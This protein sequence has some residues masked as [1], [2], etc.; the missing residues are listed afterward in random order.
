MTAPLPWIE[1]NHLA[2]MT[3]RVEESITFYKT[4]LGFRQVERPNFDFRGAWLVKNGICIHLLENPLAG[5]PAQ[6][7]PAHTIPTRE[8]HHAIHTDDIRAAEKLLQE[9]GVPYRR[10]WMAN[11]DL[12]QLFFQDPDGNV[13]EIATYRP[14]PPFLV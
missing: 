12:E 8:H 2:L 9:H 1:M 13:W 5:D 4:V 7:D 14:T 3:K 11:T 10:N 6:T